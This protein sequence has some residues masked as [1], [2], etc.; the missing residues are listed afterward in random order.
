MTDTNELRKVVVVTTL[1]E[2]D[3]MSILHCHPLYLSDPFKEYTEY[4]GWWRCDLCG[5]RY[6]R[7]ELMYHC[8][9]CCYDVCASC[10][11]QVVAHHRHIGHTFTPDYS[12][13]GKCCDCKK[14]SDVMYK[15][16][17]CV[18][19]YCKDCFQSIASFGLHNHPL[20]IADP[21]V[22]YP[23]KYWKCDKCFTVFG[24]DKFT[25]MFHCRE[26]NVDFCFNCFVKSLNVVK[27]CKC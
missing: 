20:Y 13:R 6:K 9:Y 8:P 4:D 24:K 10:Y 21:G 3:P 25:L 16:N 11:Y 18:I 19:Q 5:D 1:S 15:C 27:P 23:G 7:N 26:C 22:V 12:G 14:E 2:S 17:Q